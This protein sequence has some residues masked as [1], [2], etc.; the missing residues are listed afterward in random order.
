MKDFDGIII[1]A[2]PVGSV[3]AQNIAQNV[4]NIN[5]RWIHNF[6]QTKG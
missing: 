3:T 5:T 4:G 1:G 2:D 6:Y